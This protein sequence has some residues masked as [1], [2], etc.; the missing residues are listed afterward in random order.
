M[1]TDR[2]SVKS[3]FPRIF[4]RFFRGDKS[5]DRKIGGT[6]LGL[7]IVQNISLKLTVRTVNVRSKINVGS[8]FWLYPCPQAQNTTLN[9]LESVRR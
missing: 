7:A 5:R 9:I 4:E 3:Y 6:G 2:E 1:M 8:T